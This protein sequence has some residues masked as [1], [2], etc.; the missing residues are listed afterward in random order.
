VR[1]ILL[2]GDRR[3]RAAAQATM[4]AVRAAMRLG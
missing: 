1:D 2:D 3:A 4:E